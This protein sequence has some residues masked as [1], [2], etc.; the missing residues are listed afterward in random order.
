MLVESA[1]EGRQPVPVAGDD[2]PA[3]QCALEPSERLRLMLYV[4]ASADAL[5]DRGAARDSR[6]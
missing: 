5:R 3:A 1:F 4:A 6:L 2:E